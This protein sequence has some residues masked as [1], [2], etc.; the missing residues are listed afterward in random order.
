[1]SEEEIPYDYRDEAQ[2]RRIM[3][4]Q[5]AGVGWRTA[6]LLGEIASS[7]SFYFDKL[8]QIRMPSWSR[9]R[10]A[11]V[12]DA[13]YCASPAAG[14]GGS[15]AIGGA[16]ALGDAMRSAAGDYALAFRTYDENLRPFINKVQADA[17]RVGLETLVPRTEEAIRERNSKTEAEF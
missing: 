9:G 15:L 14:M 4:D 16:A 8:L 13:A 2:Q 1:M 10:V 7:K 17:V 12:G 3:A 5:F 11:L 6:E